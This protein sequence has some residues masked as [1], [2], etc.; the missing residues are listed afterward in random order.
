MARTRARAMARTRARGNDNSLFSL[1]IG[2]YAHEYTYLYTQ[3]DVHIYIVHNYCGTM[4]NEIK[5]Q[6]TMYGGK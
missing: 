5:I 6:N 1:Y 4:R 3:E 2:Q